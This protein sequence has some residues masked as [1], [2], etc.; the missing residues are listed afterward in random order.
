MLSWLT[1]PVDMAVPHVLSTEVMVVHVC[2]MQWQRCSVL[3]LAATEAA[4]LKLY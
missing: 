1:A 4:H 2:L 3:S